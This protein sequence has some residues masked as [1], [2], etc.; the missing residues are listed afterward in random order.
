MISILFHFLFPVLGAAGAAADAIKLALE[1]S[2]LPAGSLLEVA[3]VAAQAAR[4]TMS[5]T[6]GSLLEATNVSGG[7][8]LEI[9]NVS[10]PVVQ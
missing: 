8:L 10:N 4:E 9:G 6:A 3:N 7:S 5:G 1:A 2:N